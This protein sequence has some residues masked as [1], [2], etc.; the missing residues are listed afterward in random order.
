MGS[1]CASLVWYGDMQRP[2]GRMFKTALL[3]VLWATIFSDEA[4][5]SKA[6]GSAYR[7]VLRVSFPPA[8]PVVRARH[9]RQASRRARMLQMG[10]ADSAQWRGVLSDARLSQ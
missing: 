5:S 4:G 8:T 10:Q 9:M 7:W 6:W 3:P 2:L 1:P